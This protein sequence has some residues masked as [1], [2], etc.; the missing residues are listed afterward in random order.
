MIRPRL[1]LLA[2][3]ALMLALALALAAP[4]AAQGPPG[5]ALGSYPARAGDTDIP[6][7]VKLPQLNPST[8]PD[9]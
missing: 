4:V 8:S 7:N 2:L 9:G 3:P 6:F 5:F 1:L